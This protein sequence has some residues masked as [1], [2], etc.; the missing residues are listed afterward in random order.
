ME[1]EY[2]VSTVGSEQIL[3]PIQV[4]RPY[5]FTCVNCP[6]VPDRDDEPDYQRIMRRSGKNVGYTKSVNLEYPTRC[7]S[8]ETKK[9]RFQRMRKRV[10][11]VWDRS[12]HERMGVPAVLTITY[13]SEWTFNESPEGEV[14]ALL[15]ALPRARKIMQN[16]GI[17]GGTY[18]VECTTRDSSCMMEI[19]AYKHHAHV[20]MVAVGPYVNSSEWED[21]CNMLT[22]LGLGRIWYEKRSPG[23]DEDWCS[24]KRCRHKKDWKGLRDGIAGYISKYI[25]KTAR[26][27]RTWGVMRNRLPTN[28][29]PHESRDGLQCK[30]AQPYQRT[31][32]RCPSPD[33]LPSLLEFCELRNPGPVVVRRLDNLRLRSELLFQQPS[34][35]SPSSSE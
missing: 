12:F 18:V 33:H 28:P 22:P 34:T 24:D 14:A 2:D 16:A 3:S 30:L 9:K 27:C 19:P 11:A 26:G 35:S 31:S 32:L 13:P 8:C 4:K 1:N 20:H 6:W 29:S 7:A 10:K 25:T 23:C 17:L 15:K 5:G 21:W